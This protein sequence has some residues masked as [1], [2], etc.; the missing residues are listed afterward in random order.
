MSDAVEKT[1]PDA[2]KK[3]GGVRVDAPRKRPEHNDNAPAIPQTNITAA[4]GEC[5]LFLYC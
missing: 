3:V 4:L 5:L 2:A 1:M